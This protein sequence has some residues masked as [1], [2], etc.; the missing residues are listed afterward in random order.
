MKHLLI[1]VHLSEVPDFLGSPR[2]RNV[3]F[4]SVACIEDSRWSYASLVYEGLHCFQRVR[5]ALLFDAPF[6]VHFFL[7]SPDTSYVYLISTI[8]DQNQLPRP[9]SSQ[10]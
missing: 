8:L 2:A 6:G 10:D 5:S 3:S 1:S 4:L 9:F 7:G